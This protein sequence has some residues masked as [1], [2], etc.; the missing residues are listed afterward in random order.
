MKK[1]K[2]DLDA[3]EVDSFHP[4]PQEGGEGTVHGE[5]IGIT[6][7]C[8]GGY[9]ACLSMVM[10]TCGGP[11]RCGGVHACW[12]HAAVG[13]ASA[14][15]ATVCGGIH[16]CG[17][18]CMPTCGGPTQCGGI[19]TCGY[20][21]QPTCGGPTQCG[22]IQTCGYSCQ[23]TCAG[24]TACGGIHTC[25]PTCPPS[26]DWTCFECGPTQAAGTCSPFCA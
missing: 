12:P 11:T 1:L 14:G 22:G 10:L 25:Q 24:P 5:Q 2:L 3:L 26:G 17:Q 4:M 6:G 9:G 15:G 7:W 8:S 18:S 13:F 16:T 20:S 19:H 23:P 21:C